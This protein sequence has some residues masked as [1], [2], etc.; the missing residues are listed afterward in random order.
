MEH[1]LLSPSRSA[2]YPSDGEVVVN[3]VVKR[4]GLQR[5]L[6]VRGASVFCEMMTRFAAAADDA[7]TLGGRTSEQRIRG[8]SVRRRSLRKTRANFQSV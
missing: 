7:T 5:G 1:C 2:A 8:T 4:R 6:V 3:A